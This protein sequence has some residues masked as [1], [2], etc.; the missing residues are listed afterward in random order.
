MEQQPPNSI[1]AFLRQLLQHMEETTFIHH[2]SKQHSWSLNYKNG[3]KNK[4]LPAHHTY[5]TYKLP[6]SSMSWSQNEHQNLSRRRSSSCN[7]T[8]SVRC[9]RTSWIFFLALLRNSAKFCLC[10]TPY[11]WPFPLSW[12]CRQTR[13]NINCFI[14]CQLSATI[15]TLL[16][17]VTP[18]WD[19]P[20]CHKP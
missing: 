18:S 1:F 20:A 11:L 10:L 17:F 2:L 8:A 9:N 12:F 15:I 3:I 16:N 19:S 5:R 6:L 4:R 14:I 13:Q 7:R